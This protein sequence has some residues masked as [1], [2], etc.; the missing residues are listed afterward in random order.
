MLAK[1]KVLLFINNSILDKSSSFVSFYIYA[2]TA[3]LRWGKCFSLRSWRWV[4]LLRSSL[5]RARR[6]ARVF[7]ARRSMGYLQ[8]KHT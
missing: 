6:M 2:L 3:Y 5:V 1:K 7:L 4:L 8:E